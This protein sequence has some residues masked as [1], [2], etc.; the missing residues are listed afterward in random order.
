MQQS[1]NNDNNQTRNK[2]KII[3]PSIG[4]ATKE[5]IET[6]SEVIIEGGL[7]IQ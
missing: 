7:Q 5:A 6:D 3:A 4:E 1:R 2:R